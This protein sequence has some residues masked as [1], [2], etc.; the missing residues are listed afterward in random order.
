MIKNKIRNRN[1]RS[2][3]RFKTKQSNLNHIQ[4][5]VVN[6]LNNAK[7]KSQHTLIELSVKQWMRFSKNS[8]Y[9]KGMYENGTGNEKRILY[10]EVSIGQNLKFKKRSHKS[11]GSVLRWKTPL[12]ANIQGRF[13][14]VVIDKSEIIAHSPNILIIDGSSQ[15]G[16]NYIEGS[17][18]SPSGK[19]ILFLGRITM[20]D[21]AS[22]YIWGKEEATFLKSCKPNLIKGNSQHFGST[23]K[24]YSFGNIAN[25]R[26]IGKSSVTQ[27]VHKRFKLE[28]RTLIAQND[29]EYMESMVGK[30][31]IYSIEGLCKLIPNLKDYM[32]PA[33]NVAYNIQ[34]DIGSCNIAKTKTSD[35]GL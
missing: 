35:A 26:L 18:Y 30:E 2:A 31:L 21:N 9:L 23:G 28:H 13:M 32:A 19:V 20:N 1:N 4:H 12:L 8:I 6:Q 33:L 22:K 10:R 16:G 11:H 34:A 29:S 7:L 5:K 27:Y 15:Q 3:L 25:Y 24:Y 14:V 17:K